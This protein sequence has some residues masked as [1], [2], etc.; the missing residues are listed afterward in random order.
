MRLSFLSTSIWAGIAAFLLSAGGSWAQQR[1]PVEDPSNLSAPY[2][3]PPVHDCALA[4]PV[5]GFRENALVTVFADGVPVGTKPDAKP[6]LDGSADIPLTRPLV[7]GETLTATQTV[8]SISS[9]HSHDPVPVTNYPTL[10]KPVVIPDI[11]QCGRVVPVGNLVASTHV[12]VWDT[13]APPPPFLG[14]GETTGDRTG[15]FSVIS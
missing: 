13:A 14:S 1:F 10:T 15:I 8:D 9:G 2:I 6:D 5:S 12:D 3:L 7:L 4:V 11:Y